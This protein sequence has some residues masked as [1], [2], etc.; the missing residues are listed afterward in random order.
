ML[1]TC[2]VPCANAFQSAC[3]RTCMASCA[4]PHA[5]LYT[6]SRPM[7][8][9]VCVC[10]PLRSRGGSTTHG[11]V[12]NRTIRI[13]PSC[14][15][16]RTVTHGR[17]AGSGSG[18]NVSVGQGRRYTRQKRRRADPR[19]TGGSLGCR[20]HVCMFASRLCTVCAHLRPCVHT[21]CSAV[22]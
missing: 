13:R 5:Q 19:S 1:A 3:A 20:K 11:P 22:V 6:E 9:C 21:V 14:T 10:V 7:C 16:Q 17:T 4:A 2:C 15:R 12:P 18:C 8:V